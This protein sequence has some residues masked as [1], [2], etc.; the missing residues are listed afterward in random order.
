MYA[1]NVAVIF[2]SSFFLKNEI[3]IFLYFFK[4]AVYDKVNKSSQFYLFSRSL[5][6]T[7]VTGIRLK[8]RE[9]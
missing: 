6:Q 2:S 1:E 3:N 7:A 9:T 8:T 5:H 4:Q